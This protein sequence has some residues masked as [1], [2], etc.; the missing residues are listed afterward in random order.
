ML[1]NYLKVAWRSLLKGRIFSLINI[2]GLASGL[3]C[4]ILIALY[5][6]DELSY[7]RFNEK[8]SRIYRINSEI[9]FGGNN[10]HLAVC[11]DPMGAALKKDYPQVE[12]YVR[13]YNS[14]GYK[15]LKKGNEYIRENNVANADSTLFNVFTLPSVAGDTKTALNEPNTVVITESSAR[16]YFGTTDVLGKNIETDENKSTLYKITAVIKDIPHNSHFNFDFIFSM[17]NVQY[18]WG[19]FLSH[20]FQ[21]YIVLKAGTDYKAFEKNFMQVVDKYIL[22]QAK[23]FM[24]INSM[25]EFAKAGNRLEYSLMPLTDIHLHSDRYPELGVN[26]N[27]QYVYIFSAVALFVLL[28]ACINFMN[29]STARSSNRAKEVG[30]RKVMGSERRS[31]IRQFLT[32]STLTAVISTAFAVVIAWICLSWFNNLSGKQLAISELVQPKY[33]FFLL[34]LPFIVGIMAGG[35][36][37]F[38]LSSFKP[39]SVLKGKTNAGFKRSTLR[40]VLV[41]FQFT[42]SIILIVGTIIVYRQ[43]NYIQTKKLGFSKDQVLVINGT[44]ALGNNSTAFKT[45]VAKLSG[46]TGS[47]FAGFLPVSNSSRNDNTY[48]KEAVM[49]SKNGLNMQT[50]VIDYDYLNVMGMELLSGRNFSKD[51]GTDSSAI[52][53]NEST[54]KVLGYDNPVGKKLYTYFQD[55]FSTRLISYD[56]IGVVKNFH[57]ESLRQNIGPLCF[58]LGNSSW[59]TAFKVNTSN[60]RELVSGVE[61]KWKAMAPGMPFSYQFLDEAFDEMYRVEQRTGKLGLSLG[62]IAILIACLGL[63]GLA[64]YTAEQRIK[65]IGVRKV[66]GASVGN[67]VSMLSKDFMKL[68]LISSVIAVP[69]SWWAMNKWLQDFAYRINVGW[70]I[71]ITAGAIALIIALLTISLQTIKAAVANPVKSLRTE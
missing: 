1:K 19:N 13:F 41:I 54:A 34:A 5:V 38:Y 64:S 25:E 43:L 9:L 44:G 35:Y 29:L 24:N 37:A 59:V 45:E 14:N 18:Q 31:L 51:F 40:N 32:E 6:A 46:V 17:D 4:F 3:A 55:Q 33:L 71:F 20:N 2:T 52:I 27:I 42:T 66:L 53:I 21:T 69:L 11:S 22:P 68:V 56:I 62:I 47:T 23:Q 49:D 63:F 58:R 60:I 16:K 65:E 15:M 26:G 30:I 67:I 70:W 39:I 61:S 48:S 10:L 57:Y 50:W 8:A 7:D 36:P 12:E 28:L